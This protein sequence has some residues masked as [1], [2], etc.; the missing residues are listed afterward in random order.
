LIFA[1][2]ISNALESVG[3]EKIS[4]PE[5]FQRQGINQQEIKKLTNYNKEFIE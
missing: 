2:N 3:P 1:G 5:Q 4:D